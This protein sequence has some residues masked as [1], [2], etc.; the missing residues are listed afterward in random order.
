MSIGIEGIEEGELRPIREIEK[1]DELEGFANPEQVRKVNDIARAHITPD[2]PHARD[3]SL[4]GRV[5]EGEVPRVRPTEGAPSGEKPSAEVE[6]LS[7]PMIRHKLELA[8]SEVRE[9]RNRLQGENPP[10]P[11]EFKFPN[12]A[13]EAVQLALA[14]EAWTDEQLKKHVAEAKGHQKDI[15][16]LL[17][18]S[19]E[20]TG[21]KD[22]QKEI[23]PA[24]QQKFDELKERGIDLWK[25]E[26]KTLTKE[27]IFEIKSLSSAQV[28][29][30]RSNLQIIFVSKLQPLIQAMGAILEGFRKIVSDSDRVIRKTL[31]LRH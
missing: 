2:V 29:K 16:L 30:L 15:D 21:L 20:L 27:K 13:W 25:G 24:L 4:R 31:E 19:A 11:H 14:K 8:R 3:S 1:R 28:D 10:A 9:I 5:S 6:S 18:V 23:T 22:G 26:D 12:L 17:D 7:I